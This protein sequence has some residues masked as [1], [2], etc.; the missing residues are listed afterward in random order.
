[1]NESSKSNGRPGPFRRIQG[2]VT[3]ANVV[4]TL[5]LFLAIG[6]SGAYA[7][8]EWT[9]KNIKNGTVASVD[10]K[11]NSL[12]SVDL[13]NGSVSGVDIKDGSLTAVDLAA[14]VLIAD[15]A[16]GVVTGDQIAAGAVTSQ[17][18][19]DETL[20]GD[21]V[22]NGEIG[23]GDLRS[24]AVTG[25]KIAAG[26]VKSEHVAN[27]TITG[28]DIKNGTLGDAQVQDNSL[29]TFDLGENSVDS[30]EVLDF[31]LT[32]EDI[33]VLFAQVA[34]NG[35]LSSSSGGVTS[36]RLGLGQYEVDFGRNISSA[37]FIAT[38]G[39]AGSGGA[40]GAIIGVADRS[41]NNEA[42]FVSVRDADGNL[43]DR[44]FQ[45]VVVT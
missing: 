37:A 4:S 14:G 45:L 40:S 32:N 33:G 38:Q 29:T 41:G 22:K 3:Y 9:G 8:N 10:V 35:T 19:A 13:K 16:T 25:E 6:T 5:A 17:H 12:A 31:G 24:G 20:T 39:E 36:L 18:V 23:E 11:N 7:A 15:V 1:M 44:A 28:A 42:V 21:D 26:E 2:H 30:D 43:V 27:G 34:G